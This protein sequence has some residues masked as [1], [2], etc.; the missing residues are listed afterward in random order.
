MKVSRSCTLKKYLQNY[1]CDVTY[2]N[3][4]RPLIRI[5][6]LPWFLGWRSNNKWNWFYFLSEH[7]RSQ[8]KYC[9][10]FSIIV[11]FAN[12]L[13]YVSKFTIV[14]FQKSRN[15]IMVTFAPK[16]IGWQDNTRAEFSTAYVGI[17]LNNKR[18]SFKLK[19][20]PQKHT[21]RC[22]KYTKAILVI[23]ESN[24]H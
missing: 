4:H 8:E 14:T 6:H 12:A 1:F 23:V 2:Q 7:T 15:Y 18:T 13:R 16:S 3:Y 20:R 22:N 11:L 17:L 5:Q 21:F 10:Y 9:C 19:I 24:K